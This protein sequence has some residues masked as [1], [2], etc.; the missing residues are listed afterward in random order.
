MLDLALKNILRQKTRTA[1]TV[2]GIMIGIAAIVA[3]GSISEGLRVMVTQQLEQT[4][5]MITVIQQG[6]GGLIS[7]YLRSSLTEEQVNE[8]LSY[9]GVKTGTPV[10]IISGY[11]DENKKFG[12]PDLFRIGVDASNIDLY[13]TEAVKIEE[14]EKIAPGD[15]DYINIGFRLADKLGLEVGDTYEI[16]GTSLTV[17]GIFQEF[18]DPQV[19]DAII[20]PIETAKELFARDT[21]VAVIL[22]PENIED[23]ED[24]AQDLNDN[25]KGIYAFTASQLSQQISQII[26]QIGFFT[27]GIAAIS[28]IVG[29]LGVM[30]T[31]IMSVMERRRE[32]GVL[33]AIG[34]T[35]SY[36]IRMIII[37]SVL[38]SVIG[39][40]V[41]LGVGYLGAKALEIA[42]NYNAKG[43]VTP[44]LA[45]YSFIFA[46]FLGILG[47]FYPAKK[48]A[49]LSP[50]EAL[51]YE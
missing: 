41:G 16:N 44:R 47:G 3:L 4:T 22:Y 51:R 48:A 18:G 40:A 8:I 10:I 28:A 1:L 24:L 31:M 2:I 7:N 27:I 35:R 45:L 29:G 23:A 49:E 32:I 38:I 33:R 26:D 39:G 21:Y 15:R 6:E 11:I 14:G 17:K 20:M 30:N 19:D 34:A 46:I 25:I 50:I 5:G 12:Q 43:I 42:T 37:E 9:P 36:V 13:T